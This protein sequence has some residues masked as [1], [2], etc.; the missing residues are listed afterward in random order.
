MA[1]FRNSFVIEE[2]EQ[3]IATLQAPKRPSAVASQSVASFPVRLTHSALLCRICTEVP[4]LLPAGLVVKICETRPDPPRASRRGER[5][6]SVP[7]TTPR[8]RRTGSRTS[9]GIELA[10]NFRIAIRYYRSAL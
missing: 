7:I 4:R 1:A 9:S 3:A 5:R 6:G 10:S 2:H 8:W